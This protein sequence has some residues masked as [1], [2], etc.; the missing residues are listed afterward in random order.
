[1]VATPVGARCRKC[2]GVK[3]LPTYQISPLQYAKAIGAGIAVAVAIGIAWAWLHSAVTILAWSLMVGMILGAGAAL[4]IA[5]AVSRVINRKRGMPLQIIAGACFVLC[6]V[7][8]WAGISKGALTF[9]L[10]FNLTHIIVVIVGI[11]VAAARLR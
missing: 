7:I 9:F 5:E 11:I 1:M 4:A 10:N 2:A 8:S 3:R 6:Y